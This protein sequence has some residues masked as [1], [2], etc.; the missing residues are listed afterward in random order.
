[1]KKLLLMA[2]LAVGMTAH[3]GSLLSNDD[4]H[5]TDLVLKE[6]E[7]GDWTMH[8]GAGVNLVTGAPADYEF[9]AFRSWEFQWTVA[10]YDYHPKGASQTYSVGLGLNWKNYGLKDNGSMFVKNSNDVIELGHFAKDAGSR[11]SRIHTLAINIPLLFTQKLGKDCSLSVGP[12]VNFNVG[13][14]VSNDWED[15]DMDYDISTRKIG[16]RVVTVDVMGVFDISGFGFYCKYA[17]MSVLQNDRGPEFKS[18]SLGL[19]F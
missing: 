4:S 1:M 5:S 3:A 13:G 19:Y 8:F 15:G 11:S 14:W 2:F 7:K 9:A 16:Q 12:I 6:G 17:P 18:I 10:Q